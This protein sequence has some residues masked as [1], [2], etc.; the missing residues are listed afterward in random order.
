MGG[1]LPL[2]AP[3]RNAP[4]R[5]P[6]LKPWGRPNGDA[7]A[8]DTPAFASLAGRYEFGDLALPVGR[9]PCLRDPIAKAPPIVGAA[10]HRFAGNVDYLVGLERAL[11]GFDVAHVADLSFPYSLQAVRARDAGACGRVVVTGWENIEFPPWENALVARRVERVA[12]G[13]DQ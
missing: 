9:L 7:I 10:V 13:G 11:R 3:L 5:G 8:P 12:A 1:K 6:D 4:L 2:S